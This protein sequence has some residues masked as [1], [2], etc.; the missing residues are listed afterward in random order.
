MM[1]VMMMWVIMTMT[2]IIRIEFVEYI[3]RVDE[4]KTLAAEELNLLTIQRK[5]YKLPPREETMANINKLHEQ[6]RGIEQS[7][8][9]F[10]K[11][12]KI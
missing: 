3:S 1:M 8:K 7:V 10:V 5:N 11:F 12:R 6:R 9:K 2:I 4:L